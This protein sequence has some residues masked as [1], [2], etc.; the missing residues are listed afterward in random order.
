MAG[1]CCCQH[2]PLES[3]PMGALAVIAGSIWGLPSLASPSEAGWGSCSPAQHSSGSRILP[4]TQYCCLALCA[5]FS[6]AKEESSAS[7]VLVLSSASCKVY[8]PSAQVCSP[9]ERDPKFQVPSKGLNIPVGASLHWIQPL[10][11][12]RG[13]LLTLG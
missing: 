9:S 7:Q 3:A 12:A 6:M 8:S 4:G 10:P 11:A 13:L 5:C 1:V 2:P